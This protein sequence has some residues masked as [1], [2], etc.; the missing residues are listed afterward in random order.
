MQAEHRRVRDQLPLAGRND[1]VEP[2]Q[3]TLLETDSGRREHD[4]VRVPRDGVGAFAVEGLA[5]DVQRM[6][7]LLVAR[8]RPRAVARTSPRGLG[9]DVDQHREGA[10]SQRGPNLGAR[11]RAAP[12]REHPR[13]LAPESLDRLLG[14]EHP[15][16]LL[17]QLDER[18]WDRAPE[19][20]LELAVEI[21]EG[22]AE[23]FRDLRAQSRLAG[24]H[25]PD[26]GDVPV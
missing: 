6:E 3:R 21:D 7:E 15:E 20:S 24:A 13:R 14:L 1:L 16:P 22:P 8:E 26:Q 2:C 12:E 23:P 11:D 17:A 19:R 18:L 9:I 10:I 25:E 5:L 4:P